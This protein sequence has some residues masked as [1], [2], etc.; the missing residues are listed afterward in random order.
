MVG[1]F[2]IMEAALNLFIAYTC[3]LK[4]GF[5]GTLVFCEGVLMV[6]YIN[7]ESVGIICAVLNN[8]P[9]PIFIFN[10]DNLMILE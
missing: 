6:P 9:L 7:D 5:V 4:P 10:N 2:V 1:L 3:A 8:S